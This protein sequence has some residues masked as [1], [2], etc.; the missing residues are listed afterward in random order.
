MVANLIPQLFKIQVGNPRFKIKYMNTKLIKFL[1]I[2]KYCGP[3][4]LCLAVVV[5][6]V[7]WPAIIC[8]PACMLDERTTTTVVDSSNGAVLS[9]QQNQPQFMLPV[10]VAQPQTVYVQQQSQQPQYVQV[11]HA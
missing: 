6:L 9:V 2:E 11:Q 10:V 1:L 7:F 5:L 8:V 4:T 3:Q